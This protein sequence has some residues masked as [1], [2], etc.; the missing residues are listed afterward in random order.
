MDVFPSKE[1]H[2]LLSSTSF[3][4]LL[5]YA[6]LIAL[7]LGLSSSKHGVETL[8]TVITDEGA[9][10]GCATFSDADLCRE[11]A[12]DLGTAASAEGADLI[13]SGRC[14]RSARLQETDA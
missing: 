3:P 2:F 14:Q 6:H 1:T 8:H 5:S 7:P 13:G 4:F 10:R 12:G 11:E 9:G